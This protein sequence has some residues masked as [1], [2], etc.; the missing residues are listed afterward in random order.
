[1][2]HVERRTPTEIVRAVIET[3]PAPPSTVAPPERRRALRGDLDV[4]ALT[5]LKK[6]PGRRYQTVEKF[7]GD[8]GRH[9]DGLPVT[10][11]PDTW[12]YRAAKFG[13]R[14]RLAVA[15][16]AA[17]AVS[18]VAG[19]AGT[20]WQARVAAERARVAS[21]EAAKQRAVRDFLVRLFEAATPGQTLGR[22]PTARELL[23]RGRRELDTALAAEPEVRAELLAA[24][25]R[26]YGALGLVPQAD[27]LFE[28]AVTLAR[29]LGGEA[30]PT[31][32][33]ALTGWAGSLVMQSQFDR[34][35][36]MLR[37]AIE[38]L[39]RRDPDDPE[40]ALP[41]RSLGRVYTFTGKHDSAETLLRRALAMDVRRHGP[42]SPQ[43]A[44]S[45]DD[46]GFELLRQ[47]DLPAADSAIGAALAIWRRVLPP[48][49]PSLLWTLSNL[50][51][52]R[53]E[54]GDRA[55]A[56]RLLREVVA[57]Q[58]RIYPR[59]H[60]ELAHSMMWLGSLLAH[61]ERWAEAESLTAPA[62]EQHRA[63]LGA[64]NDHV[65]MLREDLSE[66]RYRQGRFREAERDIREALAAWRRTLGPEH[67]TTL[68]AT[69]KLAINLR[70]QGRYA[71]AEA[72]FRETLEVRR[73]RLGDSTPD[74]A[75]SLLGLG[76]L[77][78]LAGHPDEA[79]PLL[80][81]ALAISRAAD[82]DG[83]DASRVLG[84]LGAVLSDRGK[85]AEA[86]PLLREALVG[87]TTHLGA[88]HTETAATREELG[89]TLALGGRYAEAEPV[90]LEAFRHLERKHDFWGVRERRETARSLEE[91][92]RKTGNA[93]AARRY[94]RLADSATPPVRHPSASSARSP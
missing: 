40:L 80:R 43:A 3:Q 76:M 70:E 72:L 12:R 4:I 30:D 71:E 33:G 13:R 2:H 86:E 35:A 18:L 36:P 92:Y 83:L 51:A 23:D 57:G 45:Y 59:G 44:S 89:H 91:L 90:L 39:R 75:R 53:E 31:L 55:E 21:A 47:D 34:A 26:T 94:G 67:R 85:L 16:G 74:V 52:L 78:R 88:T 17:V 56:E 77:K 82:P 8:I 25:A 20:V 58:Q 61:D 66:F 11:R 65:T 22:D 29:T 69:D 54:Q 84:Q 63:L 50:S 41:L 81:E 19:L 1:A 64:D 27:S 5:A 42:E 15:A 49:H 32:A 10:A 37:E 60:P 79:E 73:R 68:A 62:V 24:V 28:Q 14:H 6:E 9:L 48:D 93:G 87:Q 7:A 38:R 46:L